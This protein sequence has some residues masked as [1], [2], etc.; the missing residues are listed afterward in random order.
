MGHKYAYLL[1]SIIIYCAL[2][3][4]SV[5]V[6]TNLIAIKIMPANI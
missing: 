2:C 1:A 6:Y 3:A 4:Q 5:Q